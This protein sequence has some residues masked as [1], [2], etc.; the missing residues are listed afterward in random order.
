MKPNIALLSGGYSGEAVVSIESAAVIAKNIDHNKY[1][2]F[3]VKISQN[4]WLCEYEDRDIEVNK[5]DFSINAGTKNIKFDLAFIMIHGSPGEDG[6][7]QSYF[8]MLNIP[9]TSCSAMVASLTFNKYYTLQL[10]KSFGIAVSDSI[11]LNNKNTEISAEEIKKLHFPVFVKPNSGG[12]SIGMSKVSDPTNLKK[13]IEKAF[14]EDTEVLI[15]AYQSGDELTCAVMRHKNK[16]ISFPLTLIR[17]KKDFFDFEAKYTQGMADEITPP[18]VDQKLIDDVKKQSEWLYEKMNCRGLVRFDFIHKG[19]TSI[20]L[21][22]NTI[23]G[24]SSASIVPQQARAAGISETKL[25]DMIIENAL[26][27]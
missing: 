14:V 12:S 26:L 11:Y 24:M 10:V 21:E 19:K 4:N 18:P 15:E 27:F 5:H 13:A 20:F 7:L 6:L 1:N 8:E 9:H 17:S 16:I 2:V 22:V 25:Y 3:L 23:P